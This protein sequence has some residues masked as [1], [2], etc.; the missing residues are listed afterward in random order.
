MLVRVEGGDDIGSD[1]PVLSLVPDQRVG[2]IVNGT[3]SACEDLKFKEE[4]GG[5]GKCRDLSVEG[6]SLLLWGVSHT[7]LFSLL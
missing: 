6:I 5:R 3:T 4:E 2:G 7:S 1:A